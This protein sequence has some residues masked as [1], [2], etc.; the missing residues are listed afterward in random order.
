MRW[1]SLTD[2]RVVGLRFTFEDLLRGAAS[3]RPWLP[4]AEFVRLTEEDT[5]FLHLDFH[6]AAGWCCGIVPFCGKERC[7]ARGR[8]LDAVAKTSLLGCASPDHL[9][10]NT[11]RVV[12]WIWRTSPGFRMT[13]NTQS[14]GKHILQL[15]SVSVLSTDAKSRR[16]LI[17]LAPSSAPLLYDGK[18]AK[19]QNM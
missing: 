5:Y 3:E 18:N 16:S 15:S 19:G 10:S 14:D 4:G 11:L 17:R 9:A 6:L 1:E 8:W 2:M 7:G 13:G 12:L